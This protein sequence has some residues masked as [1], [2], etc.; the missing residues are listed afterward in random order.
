M[1]LIKNCTLIDGVSAKPVKNALVVF[2]GGKIC[3]AGKA[4][5]K[6]AKQYANADVI[7][8]NGRTV[9]PGL[10]DA[11]VHLCMDG[12][13][14]N[15]RQMIMTTANYAV[16]E[17]V[18]RAQRDL[19]AGFTTI[20]C[21]GEKGEVD[22]DIRNAINDGLIKGPRIL[23]SGKAITITGGHGDMF[24]GGMEIDGIAEIADG[25]DAVKRV[26]RKRIKRRV[27]NLKVMATGG[28]MSPGPATVSQL[29]IDEMHAVVVEAEKNGICTAA[30]AIGEGGCWNAVQAGIR[31]IEHGTFLNDE[32]IALMAE[33]G[34]YLMT[35]LTAFNT[36]RYGEEGGVPADHLNKVRSFAEK[37]YDGLRKAIKAGVKVGCGT[38][39]GTPFSYHG[40]NAQELTCLVEDAGMTPMEAIIAATSVTAEAIMQDDIGVLAPGK[41]ADLLIVDGDPLKDIRILQNKETIRKVYRNGEL[42]VDRDA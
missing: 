32:T 35:T 25:I 34:T 36:L 3:Y 10:I 9:M 18:L 5:A 19:E 11:H 6:A 12:L 40:N 38:D 33:K 42:L 23:A 4:N 16:I 20:R 21:C 41:T 28:G 31:T 27:D 22:I 2:D 30:H 29:N 37:H 15:F 7:D 8:A 17:G 14:D 39:T 1:K 24:P 26:A 13:P